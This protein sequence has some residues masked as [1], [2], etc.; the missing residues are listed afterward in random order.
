MSLE[1]LPPLSLAAATRF[2]EDSQKISMKRLKIVGYNFS[3]DLWSPFSDACSLLRSR[4][5]KARLK[6][7]IAV[8]SPAFVKVV[9]NLI[10]KHFRLKHSA[11]TNIRLYTAGKSVGNFET[12]ESNICIRT[13][14]SLRS[15]FSRFE[16]CVH[17]SIFSCH[18]KAW[19]FV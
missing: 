14:W 16:E 7:A 4:E 9:Q 3:W 6:K 2:W 8:K 10:A 18:A 5:N 11:T 19:Y 17:Q 15:F 12:E 13:Y 1:L